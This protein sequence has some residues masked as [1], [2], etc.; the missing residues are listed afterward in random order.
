VFRKYEKSF[1]ILVPQINIKGKHFLSDADTKRLLSGNIIITEK[2]DGANT[3]IIKHKDTFR[4]QKR[5]SL[6]DVGEHLQFN[7]FKN[8]S[9]VNYDKL[10]QIPNGLIVYGELMVCRHTIFYDA[11]PDYFIAFALYDK[12]RDKYLHRDDLIKLCETV[13]LSYVP[14][15]GRY[16]GLRKDELFDL[17]PEQSAYGQEQAEGIVVWNYQAELR[18]KVVREKFVKDMEE[19]DHWQNKAVTKNLLKNK[20]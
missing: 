2:I 5:G 13:G 6:I 12:N 10:M 18:G 14:E 4:L 19:D 8:W 17:I 11:L 7:F 1:R 3:G 16:K 20:I 9:Q 15:I